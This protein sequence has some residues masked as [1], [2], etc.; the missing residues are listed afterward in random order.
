VVVPNVEVEETERASGSANELVFERS[1]FDELLNPE[2]EGAV[3]LPNKGEGLAAGSGPVAV[4]PATSPPPGGWGTHAP[5]H[6][7]V[8]RVL[9]VNPIP[10]AEQKGTQPPGI[11]LSPRTATLLIVAVVVALAFAFGTGLLVGFHLRPAPETSSG[12]QQFRPEVVV[13]PRG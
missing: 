7:D 6:I 13:I 1:D 12:G 10:A 11:V 8:E 4:S 2:S 5:A 3:P 9:P